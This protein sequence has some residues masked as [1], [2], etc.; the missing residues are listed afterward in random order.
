MSAVRNHIA[1]LPRSRIQV[2][3]LAA[4]RTGHRRAPGTVHRRIRHLLVQPSVEDFP[5]RIRR[6]CGM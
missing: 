3:I 6:R 5:V 4:H 2:D 1:V